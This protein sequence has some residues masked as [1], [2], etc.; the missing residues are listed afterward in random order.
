MDDWDDTD[1]YAALGVARTASE[2][3]IKRAFRVLARQLHPDMHPPEWTEA[4]RAQ[5]T[6]HLQL[7]LRAWETL[8]DPERRARYDVHLQAVEARAAQRA[9]ADEERRERE[10]ARVAEHERAWRERSVRGQPAGD[11]VRWD[12]AA[13]REAELREAMAASAAYW[14]ALLAALAQPRRGA[15]VYVAVELD[16]RARREGVQIG[17]PFTD[18]DLH[19]APGTA[20]GWYVY[21]G[22][23]GWGEFG[24]PRGDLY[25]AVQHVVPHVAPSSA[26]PGRRPVPATP[27]GPGPRRVPVERPT[28]SPAARPA[29]A[30]PAAP[31]RRRRRAE[32][33]LLV[34]VAVWTLVVVLVVLALTRM[35]GL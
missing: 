22:R 16:D 23:G 28:P 35:L 12:D 13:L 19:L 18:E 26:R 30:G 24:G 32:V 4:Q 17:L 1:L 7:V 29:P 10:K 14:A 6:E 21:P 8:R 20:P 27:P 15:D 34:A 2:E 31:R 9:R 5:A 11:E 33:G 3:E 25:L